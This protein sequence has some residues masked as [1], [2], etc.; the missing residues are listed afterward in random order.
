MSPPIWRPKSPSGVRPSR[1]ECAVVAR[2]AREAAQMP[3]PAATLPVQRPSS[4]VASS[5]APA[6]STPA[7]GQY[8]SPE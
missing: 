2:R 7:S 6:P 1:A 5:G 3:R 8:R 4:A